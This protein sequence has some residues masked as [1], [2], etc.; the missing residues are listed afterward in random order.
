MR[1]IYSYSIKIANYR[2]NEWQM[3]LFR[4]SMISS[5][6]LGYAIKLYG[7]HF[8]HGNLHDLIDEYIDIEDKDFK[9]TDDLKLYIHSKED[10][11][12][13]TIDGDIILYDKLKLPKDCDMIYE[14]KGVVLSHKQ[15]TKF[16]SYLN[17]IFKHFDVESNVP[18][19]NHNI[20]YAC[21]VGI[22]KFNNQETKDLF[23]SSYYNFKKYFIE[24]IEPNIIPVVKC[25][26]A[27]IICEYLFACLL[28]G[29]RYVGKECNE[30]NS[31]THYMSS[32]KFTPI[33][34]R[35]VDSII[36][37]VNRIL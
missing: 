5:K 10:L 16:K 6:K 28:E 12:C 18:Y 4:A 23:L 13:V 20:T 32:S 17:E 35:H 2:D 3:K 11:D 1:L 14:R 25:D 22:L 26:F 24:N 29:T 27:I 7:C 15:N 8:T 37:P 19:F 30:I 9:L 33:A 34:H 21:S 36:N 31:Y